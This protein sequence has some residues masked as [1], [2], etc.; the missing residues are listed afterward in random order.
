VILLRGE[1]PGL[2]LLRAGSRSE[3]YDQ[4]EDGPFHWR[5][6]RKYAFR[7]WT[8][9]TVPG[10][11]LRLGVQ[12]RKPREVYTRNLAESAKLRGHFFNPLWFVSFRAI[13]RIKTPRDSAK[14]AANQES[15]E[16][17]S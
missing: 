6:A 12:V 17:K 1:L 10:L 2:R 16:A 3:G 11:K 5:H 15:R 9:E 8:G 13:P 7:P 4:E 14:N